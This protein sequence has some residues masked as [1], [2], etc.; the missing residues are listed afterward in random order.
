MNRKFAEIFN[1]KIG[2]VVSWGIWFLILVLTMSVIKNIRRASQIKT[3]IRTEKTKVE[4]IK[5]ENAQL[6]AQIANTQGL[7][8]V[9]K[10]IRNRLGLAKEGEW[11]VIL[12]DEEIVRKLAPK[13]QLDEDTLPDPNWKK[14]LKLFVL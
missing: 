8:F 12:P 4:K 3:E 14:W 10:E 7:E 9:E 6:E 5:S 13:T 2:K 1:I 11:M